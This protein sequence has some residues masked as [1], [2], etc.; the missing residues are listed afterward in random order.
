MAILD[1]ALSPLID[2]HSPTDG[3]STR[4]ASRNSGRLRRTLQAGDIVALAVAWGV[5]NLVAPADASLDPV[6]RVALAAPIVLVGFLLMRFQQLYLARIATMPMV[7]QARI[8]RVAVQLVVAV[9]CLDLLG[10]SDLRPMRLALGGALSF[11][12]VLA[13]RTGYRAWIQSARREGRYVRPVVLIGLDTQAGA[14]RHLIDDHPEYGFTVV[15]ALGSHSDAEAVGLADLWR[16]DLDVLE[17]LVA[18]RSITGAIV[19]T[20]ALGS[21][22]V[23][24]VTRLMHQH[25]CHVHLTTG[26]TF[27]DRRRLDPIH[28]GYE[29]LLYV[30]PLELGRAQMVAKR[31]L[32]IVLS[33]LFLILSAPVLAVAV[34]A[35]KLQDGGPVLFRQ[36]RVGIDG[37][38]FTLLKLRTMVPDAE[39]RLADV[40]D[41]NERTG[42]LFKA[43]HDP[44]VTRVG[45]VLRALSIDELPQLLNVLKG[46][47]SLVGPRPALAHEVQM[48][49]SRL[50]QRTK[51]RPGITGLWQVEARDNP[52]L[53]AYERLDL[54]YVENWSIS[55][56]VMLIVATFQSEAARMLR[57]LF[58]R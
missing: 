43:T 2:E 14:I 34:V 7:E 57:L 28:L 17:Q 9:G 4:S 44:R 49:G 26:V 11:V 25:G 48:F 12:S 41:L 47:M 37:E 51:V 3:S 24:H 45:R 58:Q 19:S 13:A 22:V 29:P 6:E 35:V 10:G 20:T 42:P 40:I 15:A 50:R 1:G 32:D 56:D 53:D 31:A 21:D 18:D 52:S 36:E 33:T 39:E 16:G 30:A 46:E 8:A 54:H 5:T 55:L 38:R 27:A 23:D